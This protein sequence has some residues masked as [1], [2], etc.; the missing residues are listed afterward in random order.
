MEMIQGAQALECF[1]ENVRNE[2]GAILPKDGTVAESTSNVLV[3]LEQLTEYADTVGIVLK[4]QNETDSA[5][6]A[7]S[8]QSESQHRI[9][10]GLYTSEYLILFFFLCNDYISK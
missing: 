9:A 3:F 7:V 5:N 8:K 1:G 10:L 2:S 4:R 6:T